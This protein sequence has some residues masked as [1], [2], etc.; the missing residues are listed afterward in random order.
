MPNKISIA[1]WSLYLLGFGVSLISLVAPALPVVAQTTPS[2]QV[3]DARNAPLTTLVDGN[4]IS[5]KINV[6]Q[7]VSASTV[8]DFRL[9][10]VDVPVATCTIPTTQSTCQTALFPALGWAWDANRTRQTQRVVQAASAGQA[11]GESANLAITPRPVV[12]V[13][14]F[15]SNWTLTWANYLG[16]QGYLAAHGLHGYAVGDG[17][18]PGVMNAGSLAAPLARTN[19]IAQNAE[20][21]GG[22]IRNVQQATGAEQVDLV[23]HSMGGTI[24]RYYFDRVMSTRNVAQLIILGTPMAGSS[25]AVLPAAL[26]LQLPAA[27]EIQPSYMQGIFNQQITKRHGVPFHALAGTKLLK[28][29]QSPCTDVP[30]DLVVSIASV[31]AISMPVQEMTL[32][33]ID[34]NAAPEVFTDFVLPLLQTPPNAVWQVA[35][36]PSLPPTAG[37]QFTRVY[38]GRVQVGA[39]QSVTINIDPGVTV[40]NFALYDTSRSLTVQVTGASGNILKLDPTANGEIRVTDPASMV[41]LGYGFTQPKAGQWVV[42]LHPTADTPASGADYAITA[43]FNGGA[44]LL[45]TLDTLVPRVNDPVQLQVQLTAAGQTL[46]LASAEARVRRPDGQLDVYPLTIQGDSATLTLTPS[47]SGLHGVEV[48]VRAQTDTGLTID[49]AAFAVF[50]AQIT[51]VEITENR[52]SAGV[53]VGLVGLGFVVLAGGVLYWRRRTAH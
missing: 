16:A 12:L 6:S 27:L 22:Y 10:G 25:C 36:P 9:E 35:D 44:T 13:H 46:T 32:L 17:Q 5:L 14:G 48:N 11:L 4:A 33:H 3:L 2:V 47:Q 15:N 29:V 8:V 39:I 23:V 19:S 26:G 1:R 49:R 30:S 37:L 34:L 53:I 28:A 24:S 18:V 50:E 41:Y 43:Q 21:L 52:L 20:I 31:K 42:A 7:A 40:A 51:D 45:A 38:T